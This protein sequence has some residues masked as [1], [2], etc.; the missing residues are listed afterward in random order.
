V[1]LIHQVPHK[2]SVPWEWHSLPRMRLRRSQSLPLLH[3][4]NH[5][6][7]TS[8]TA[9]SVSSP[10]GHSLKTASLQT[11]FLMR[12]GKP[13]SSIHVYSLSSC[14][15]VYDKHTEF[16]GYFSPP[17]TTQVQPTPAFLCLH[18]FLLFPSSQVNPWSHAGCGR[19]GSLNK[20]GPHSS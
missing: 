20:N 3:E 18:F 16:P 15:N 1:L 10:A 14:S 4:R 9:F 8:V 12:L 6:Q 19:C 17:S 13:A 7:K 11:P 2:A 5:V